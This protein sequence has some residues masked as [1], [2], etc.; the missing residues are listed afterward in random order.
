M[1]SCLNGDVLHE[2]LLAL[3]SRMGFLLNAEDI[4]AEEVGVLL[5]IPP[6]QPALPSTIAPRPEIAQVSVKDRIE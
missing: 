4:S 5:D 1:K 3:A 6:E 2:K